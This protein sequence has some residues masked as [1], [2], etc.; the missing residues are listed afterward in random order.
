MFVIHKNWFDTLGYLC[1]PQFWH[2]YVDTYTQSIA[3]RLKR[4]VF[5]PEVIPDIVHPGSKF[6][7][8]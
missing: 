6:E 7:I 4:C 2:F 8:Q 5:V 3:R 1:P